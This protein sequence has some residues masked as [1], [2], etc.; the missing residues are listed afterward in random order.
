MQQVRPDQIR[1][2]PVALKPP[3]AA[4]IQATLAAALPSPCQCSALAG[5]AALD[6]AKA[7]E[8]LRCHHATRSLPSDAPGSGGGRDAHGEE[9]EG[10]G[11]GRPGAAWRCRAEA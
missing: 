11:K 4:S 2:P 9:V 10:T 5:A 3:T 1:L 8:I 7:E 6:R